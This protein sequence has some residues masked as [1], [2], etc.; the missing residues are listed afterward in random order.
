M[1]S[2]VGLEIIHMIE[3]LAFVEAGRGRAGAAARA[4]L[5]CSCLN[6]Y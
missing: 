1:G 6:L 2:K 4:V 5:S 3:L